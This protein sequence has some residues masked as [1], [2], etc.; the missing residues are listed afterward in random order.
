M[1]E[2]ALLGLAQVLIYKSGVKRGPGRGSSMI[3]I[4]QR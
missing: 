2:Q 3:N 1:S 4:S